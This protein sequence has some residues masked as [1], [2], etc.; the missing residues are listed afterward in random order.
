MTIEEARRLPTVLTV[1]EAGR[2]LGVHRSR[3][4]ELVAD[5]TI[6][7]IRYGRG[8]RVPTAKVLKM[9]GLEPEGGR[10]GP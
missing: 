6:P 1:A 7:V 4:Y 2:L 9:L 10:D 8:M 5:G 3:A